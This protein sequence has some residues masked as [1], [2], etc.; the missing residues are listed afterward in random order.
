MRSAGG[1]SAAARF[2][3]A[4]RA[5]HGRRHTHAARLVRT[6][7]PP[8][9]RR[10]SRRANVPAGDVV[11]QFRFLGPALRRRYTF[12]R[13]DSLGNSDLLASVRAR[14]PVREQA[15]GQ[16]RHARAGT[17]HP[18]R[19]PRPVAHGAAQGGRRGRDATICAA[20]L[21]ATQRAI[22]WRR[23]NSAMPI[24]RRRG[25]TIG[26]SPSASRRP[27]NRQGRV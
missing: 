2:V 21:A 25:R 19:P 16:T 4:R 12:W 9:R 23:I 26:P 18:S 10:A 8:R 6:P 22:P 27:D 11:R 5:R 15:T 14:V 7:T 1:G 20:R 24:R 17:V 3:P 13:P